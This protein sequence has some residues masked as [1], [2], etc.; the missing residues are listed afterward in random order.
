MNTETERA[1]L[2]QKIGERKI[3]AI[4]RGVKPGNIAEVARAL[5]AG[6]VSMMEVTFDHSG[7]NGIAE[8]LES[9]SLLRDAFAGEII[10][11]AGTVLTEEET[12]EARARGA[13]YIISPN[14]DGAVI[15]KTRQLGMLSMPGAFTPTEIVTAYKAG[16]DIV[17]LFPATIGGADYI[18][19][20]RG[21][22]A[23]IPLAAVGG[24]DAATIPAFVQAGVLCFGIGSNLVNA[25][26]V[27]AGDFAGITAVAKELVKAVQT[28]HP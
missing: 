19:A 15:A 10:F 16:A 24:V 5:L 20:V 14:V 1:E 18:K 9:L 23:H 2:L 26:K 3:I 6:G 11:G 4:V 27:A 17:K 8:T 28:A 25:T 22:L 7:T 12:A 21:P 13:R